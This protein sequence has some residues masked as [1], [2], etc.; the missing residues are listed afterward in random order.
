[1][2][3]IHLSSD[4]QHKAFS[5]AES[6]PEPITPRPDKEHQKSSAV[7]IRPSRASY[8]LC[9][10]NSE[11]LWRCNLPMILAR[12][13]PSWFTLVII[14]S[15]ACAHSSVRF[16]LDQFGNRIFSLAFCTDL[17]VIESPIRLCFHDATQKF[18]ISLNF[19][20]KAEFN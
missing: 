8:F 15:C 13:N 14:R 6:R 17:T 18:G 9:P 2:N 19:V 3:V 11:E 12:S 16:L 4:F 7:A 5:L 10:D 20:N 1:V